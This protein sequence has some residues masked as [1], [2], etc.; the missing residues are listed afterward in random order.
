MSKITDNSYDG[1]FTLDYAIWQLKKNKNIIRCPFGSLEEYA[2]KRL[3]LD[4]LDLQIVQDKEYRGTVY[5]VS[6]H[7]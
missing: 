7:A 1:S 2:I 6:K 3:Q 5:K 4:G